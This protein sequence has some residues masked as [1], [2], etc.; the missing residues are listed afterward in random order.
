MALTSLLR[1]FL[2]IDEIQSIQ[3]AEV[4]ER[5]K[6]AIHSSFLQVEV[7]QDYRVILEDKNVDAVIIATPAGDHYH[8]TKEV[9]NA[10]KHCFVEK[11]LS[12]KLYEAQ[13]LVDLAE[14]KAK[15][16]MVGHT[17]LYNAAVHKLK[18]EMDKGTLGEVY[19]L[20]SQRLNLGRI[21]TDINAL[22]NFAPHDISICLYLM[23]TEPE[24]VSAVGASYIQKS[25]EDIVFLNL[26][27]KNGVMAHIHISWLDPNKVRRMTVV[28]REQIIIYDDLAQ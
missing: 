14:A 7:L 6:K 26:G 9:L 17:F 3:V 24:W 13:E 19:Y 1:N 5:R 11:P 8:Q 28:G 10:G 2:K 21:R 27:F 22:W 16:L 20:Y 12:M 15:I 25:V 4:D 18:E 23:G